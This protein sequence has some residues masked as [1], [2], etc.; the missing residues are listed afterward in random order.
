MASPPSSQDMAAQAEPC[1][2]ARRRLIAAGASAALI[3]TGGLLVPAYAAEASAGGEDVSATEDLMREHGVLRRT[4]IVYAETAG[5][6]RSKPAEVDSGALVEA[7]RL[8]RA[9]GE[10]Y[11]ERSLEERFIFPEVR[12]AGGGPARLVETLL[13]QH[14]RGREITDYIQATAR[15]GRSGT[16]D[17]EPLAR[18]LESMARMY[19]A[20]SAWEDTLV[21]PAWKKTQSADRL[22]EMAER[23]EELEHQ[24]FGK[25]GFDD[26]VERIGRIEQTLGLADLAHY[27]APSP[28]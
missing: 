5:R 12:R 11:H 3:A 14:Q 24:Q 21:F 28:R 15:S 8:F 10:E 17:A 1:G 27:T 23:F 16:G 19:Q 7:A 25:D 18:A 26:A 6:L 2:L 20:H 22:K 13:A 9:F 4:L